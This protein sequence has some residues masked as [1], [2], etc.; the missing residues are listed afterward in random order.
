[1][2]RPGARGLSG[3]G[4]TKSRRFSYR[5][6]ED[7]KEVDALT[8]AKRRVGL[9]ETFNQT[10]SRLPLSVAWP[11]PGASQLKATV[12]P[13]WP[14]TPV[15]GRPSPAKTVRQPLALDHVAALAAVPFSKCMCSC[16]ALEKFPMKSGV[17]SLSNLTWKF[18][19]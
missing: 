13:L 7:E 17:E 11:V 18:P 4:T 9:M 15:M 8:P 14:V 2:G 3:S 10:V 5:K 16:A 6:P 1:M 19:L 12:M